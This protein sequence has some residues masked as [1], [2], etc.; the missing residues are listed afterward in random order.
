[1]HTRKKNENAQETSIYSTSYICSISWAIKSFA[2]GGSRG[3]KGYWIRSRYLRSRQT[4]SPCSNEPF[5]QITQLTQCFH[6]C[7]ISCF[8]VKKTTYRIIKY[9]GQLYVI[10]SR[11]TQLSN[12]AKLSNNYSNYFMHKSVMHQWITWG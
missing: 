7:M 11:V 9:Q 3:K 10:I 1:M 6:L 2:D 4:K 12:H 8:F 5:T